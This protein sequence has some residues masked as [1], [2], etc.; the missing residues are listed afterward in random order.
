MA[1]TEQRAGAV[2]S[3]FSG[4]ERVENAAYDLF[5]RHGVRFVGVDTVI[6]EANVAKM[7]L[8]RNF[9][10]KDELILAFLR[11]REEIW[12]NG[13]VRAET[14]RRAGTPIDQ[15][16]AVFELFD[17]WFR[18]PDFEGC[19][20][21]TTMVEYSDRSNVVRKAS[22]EHLAEIRAM[23][24]QLA[25]EAGLAGPDDFARQW[26]LLMEG[27]I[28]S[29]LAGDPEA[30]LRARELGVLLLRS[31]GVPGDAMHD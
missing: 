1:M 4:R 12:T 29:A 19:A 18:R 20:F 15:L 26:H 10:S 9:H 25:T 28:I 23:L 22:V 3:G 24:R 21:I 7:T 5:S 31:Q 14:R 13:W 17:E 6:S 16:L 27:S 2:A 11:R 30:A 8:Y